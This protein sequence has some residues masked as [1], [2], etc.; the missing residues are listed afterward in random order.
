MVGWVVG[1]LV[2]YLFLNLES[3]SNCTISMHSIFN[4]LQKHY[5]SLSISI[6]YCLLAQLTLPY[7]CRA[8]PTIH[9]CIK[10]TT[11]CTPLCVQ[12]STMDTPL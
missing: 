2:R 12:C 4:V 7:I 6:F 3:Q 11:V 10:C 5:E 1:G 8:V 9:S